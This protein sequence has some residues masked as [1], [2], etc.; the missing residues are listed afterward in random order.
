MKDY[1]VKMFA[2]DGFANQL[3]LKTMIKANAP[4]KA[5]SIMAHLLAVQ[6]IWLNRCTGL[7]AA[8]SIMWP[9]WGV[10]TLAPMIDHHTTSWIAWIDGQSPDQFEK[11]ITYK[12][13]KGDLFENNLTDVLAQVSNHGTHHR[14]QIGQHLKLAGIDPLPN[15]DYIGY[16]RYT[17]QG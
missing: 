14:A 12:N 11:K 2:Y 13:S 10:D 7:T 4:G 15:T 16:L 1:F 3:I 6:E 8:N 5:V 17:N 9:D